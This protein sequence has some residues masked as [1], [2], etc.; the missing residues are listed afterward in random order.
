MVYTV[1]VTGYTAIGYN[2]TTGVWCLKA[3]FRPSSPVS[4]KKTICGVTMIS[5]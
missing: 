4:A 3:C 2:L 5:G 1:Y